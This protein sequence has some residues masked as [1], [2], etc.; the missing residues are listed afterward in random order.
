MSAPD[1]QGLAEVLLALTRASRTT[2]RLRERDGIV[3]LAAEALAD[4]VPSMRQGPLIDVRAAATYQRLQRTGELLIQDD[5]RDADPPAP[6]ALVEQHRVLAQ[7]LAPIVRRG[8][9]VGTISVHQVGARRAWSDEDVAALR[10][11]RAQLEADPAVGCLPL[12]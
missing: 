1:Y 10:A 2:V 8:E 5:L 9:M 11:A 7:M 3:G 12:S 6:R 4:G